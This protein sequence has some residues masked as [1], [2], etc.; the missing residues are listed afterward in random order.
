MDTYGASSDAH[1]QGE[2][3]I[4]IA[5]HVYGP[6]SVHLLPCKIHHTGH[7]PVATYF[8][9]RPPLAAGGGQQGND[10]DNVAATALADAGNNSEA[11]SGGSGGGGGAGENIDTQPVVVVGEREG[12]EGGRGGAAGDQKW[13]VF[14]DDSAEH[15]ARFRGRKFVGRKVELPEGVH[16]VV[17]RE[18]PCPDG[19]RQE[20]EDV[21]S[22][23]AVETSFRDVMVWGHDQARR[24][25]TVDRGLAW[26]EISKSVNDRTPYSSVSA[27]LARKHKGIACSCA[28]PVEMP[29]R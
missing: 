24:E 1:G 17:L 12:G 6:A 4:G 20:N 10:G 8:R 22:Y 29:W 14:E 5:R 16:G 21:T 19:V 25:S 7:A 2:V 23:W 27:M 26:L 11:G 3:G 15:T 18:Q 13:Q 9:P 28:A